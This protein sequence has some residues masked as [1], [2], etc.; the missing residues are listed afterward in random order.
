MGE[1][2]DFPFFWF[3]FHE[4]KSIVSWSLFLLMIV[5]QNLIGNDSSKAQFKSFLEHNQA[6]KKPIFLILIGPEGIGKTAFLRSFAEEML[7][8]A[9]HS[10]FF[11]MKDCSWTLGKNHAIQIETPTTLKTIPLNET[12]IYENKGV[13]EINSRLQQSSISGKKVLL[14]E[15]LQR[16]TNAAMN[17]FLKT[18][19][20]P[21]PN[22]FLFATAEHESWILPT[23][24]SRAMLIRFT[25]LFDAQMQEYL[26]QELANRIDPSRHKLLIT[27]A[28][29]K[30]WTLHLLLEKSEQEPDLF[31]QINQLFSL[32]EEEGQRTQK[33]WLLKKMEDYGL[34]EIIFS[35]LIKILTEQG[36]SDSA[37]QRIQVKKLINANITQENALW[38]G[39]LSSQR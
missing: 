34:L 17:A 6:H 37:K 13:R 25:P 38:Y 7:G 16:M 30:P 21:L 3:D 1:W 31:E 10:D 23:I 39:I 8:N 9:I 26:N 2:S 36:K 35:T 19:E 15:N 11:W 33:I 12:T 28:M 5:M 32:M 20:E 18:C 4:A 27:L 29:G 24:L 14:I 22:R